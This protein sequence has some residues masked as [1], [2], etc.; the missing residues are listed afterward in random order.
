MGGGGGGGGELAHA[1]RGYRQNMFNPF[2]AGNFTGRGSER[3][4]DQ[5][6]LKIPFVLVFALLL[7]LFWFVWAGGDARTSK[8]D[9]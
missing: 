9:R 5:L 4:N 2:T 8:P 3:V 7:L 6:E 1:L